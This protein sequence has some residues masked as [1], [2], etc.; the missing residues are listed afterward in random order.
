MAW[1]DEYWKG[2]AV[3][4]V[5]TTDERIPIIEKVCRSLKEKL[6][7][8]CGY[9]SPTQPDLYTSEEY[10]GMM[11]VEKRC[12]VNHVDLLRPRAVYFMLKLL[13]KKGGTCTPFYGGEE[14]QAYD[15]LKFPKCGEAINDAHNASVHAF[16]HA[17]AEAWH[18]IKLKPGQLV[19]QFAFFE[20]FSAILSHPGS[21]TRQPCRC[22]RRTC[23]A[24]TKCWCTKSHQ[25]CVRHCRLSRSTSK[26]LLQKKTRRGRSPGIPPARGPTDTI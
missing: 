1:V 23:L 16:A 6:H 21:L 20:N 5:P 18:Q 8:P 25:L 26:V 19:P 17:E 11:A 7:S 3:T 14:L 10:F 22:S 4:A 2:K 13:W 12:K 9:M 24:T 15:P